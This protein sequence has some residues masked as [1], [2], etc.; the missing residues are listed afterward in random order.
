[1]TLHGGSIMWL[2]TT[3]TVQAIYSCMVVNQN[4]SA[5]VRATCQ[6]LKS[7]KMAA[8]SSSIAK[9]LL[10]VACARSSAPDTANSQHRDSTLCLWLMLLQVLHPASLPTSS[11]V[12]IPRLSLPTSA[13]SCSGCRYVSCTSVGCCAA[14]AFYSVGAGWPAATA[15][16]IQ[17]H[18]MRP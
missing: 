6:S 4:M 13:L 8:T 7:S 1:M 3:S 11:H 18:N 12:L 17:A 2:T 14:A 16:L 9:P 5:C 10:A 15:G